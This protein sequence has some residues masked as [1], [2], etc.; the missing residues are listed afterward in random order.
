ME[1]ATQYTTVLP[2]GSNV[3]E[4]YVITQVC[5][6]FYWLAI[7]CLENSGWLA[8]FIANQPVLLAGWPELGQLSRTSELSLV[9]DRLVLL[10]SGWLPIVN[11]DFPCFFFS[12][13]K[14]MSQ[15]GRGD[16]YTTP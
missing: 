9:V 15:S 10:N 8:V 4:V 12:Q 5:V 1:N 13:N 2:R 14:G 16:I 6:H 7:E 11:A 3:L